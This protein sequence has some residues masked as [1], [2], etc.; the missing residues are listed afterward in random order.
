MVEVFAATRLR[1]MELITILNHCHRFR[2]SRPIEIVQ[3]CFRRPAE[4][5][6][7]AP[8]TEPGVVVRSHSI[9]HYP[10]RLQGW[11]MRQGHAA[12]RDHFVKMA[13][14]KPLKGFGESHQILLKHLSEPEVLF[15]VYD[16]HCKVEAIC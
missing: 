7:I 8:R 2:G 15:Y 11:V 1:A 5:N 6:R 10:S 16:W 13:R 12:R 3:L 9:K 14:S 4:R